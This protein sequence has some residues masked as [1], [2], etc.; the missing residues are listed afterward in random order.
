VSDGPA[1]SR[2]PASAP[3]IPGTG[4]GT[5]A[6]P[7]RG[8]AIELPVSMV[9]RVSSE[10]AALEQ[11]AFG[12]ANRRRFTRLTVNISAFCHIDGVPT[13]QAV[14]DLSTGGMMLHLTTP[15]EVGKRVRVLLALP[16]ISGQKLCSL[17]GPVR[18]VRP[19]GPEGANCSA[20]VEFDVDVNPADLDTLR[21]FLM[22]WG[23]P[24]S[25]E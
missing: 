6:D 25:R 21:G 2:P 9:Q 14:G 22:L 11:A 1:S 23:S 7:A 19:G 5:A 16:Y 20:G 8:L 17:A 24:R 18:W 3:P 4:T 15:T 10:T 12:G 13:E